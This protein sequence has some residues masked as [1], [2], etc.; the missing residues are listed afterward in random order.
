[1]QPET[2]AEL[3]NTSDAS[4]RRIER[5]VEALDGG[6]RV[7]W[8]GLRVPLD[9]VIGLIPGLG[10]GIT[11]I[12]AFAVVNEARRRNVP[13]KIMLRM[14]LNIIVDFAGGLIPVAGDVFDFLYKSNRMNLRLLKG[15]LQS[16]G[17]GEAK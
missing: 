11:M 4:L 13:A 1:M 5:L 8:V 10:D 15:Y 12:L 2:I 7:P 16:E 3:P 14:I 9:P 17:G 6:V